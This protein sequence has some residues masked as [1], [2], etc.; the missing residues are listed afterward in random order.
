MFFIR[1]RD[2]TNGPW[3]Q[4]TLAPGPTTVTYPERR[5]FQLRVTPD[6]ATVISRPMRDSRTRRWVWK[7][8]RPRLTTYETQW[9]TLESLEYRTRLLAGKPPIV[10]IWEDESTIG[11]FSRMADSTT[12]EWTKVKFIRVERTIADGGGPV[13]FE[14]SFIEFT[15]EDDSYSEF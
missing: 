3:I 1:Y 10:E 8:Y 4:F 5:A 7:R 6:G 2:S 9:R 12:K 15:I 14:E 13:V 11:G